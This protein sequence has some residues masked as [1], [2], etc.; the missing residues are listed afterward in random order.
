MPTISLPPAGWLHEAVEAMQLGVTIT[1]VEGRI[2][3][4][5]PAEAEMHG[6]RVEDLIGQAASLFAPTPPTRRMSTEELRQAS[7]W[8]RET[9]NAR[10]DGSVFPVRLLSDVLRDSSGAPVAIVTISEDLTERRAA[11][12]KLQRAQKLEL[13]GQLTGGI[14]HDFNNVLT[15]VLANLDLL[16]MSEPDDAANISMLI[17]ETRQMARQGAAMARQLLGFSR[18]DALNFIATPLDQLV[19]EYRSVLRR[20]LPESIELQYESAAEVPPAAAD[21]HAVQQILLNLVTNARD[22]CDDGG[23]LSIRVEPSRI[24]GSFRASHGWGEPGDYVLISVQDTGSG[25]DA[26]TVARIFDP[27]FTTKPEGSGTGLGMAM[28]Y[29][30]M[31]QHRGFVDVESTPG[32]GTVVRLWFPVERSVH[33]PLP[34]TR[35]TGDPNLRGSETL[36]VVEDEAPIRRSIERGL[37]EYGY[38]VVAAQ[39]GQEALE[40]YREQAADID[41][42]I[43]DL[44][45]PRM[46]GRALADQLRRMG[47][48]VPILFA[49]GY[50]PEAVDAT[51]GEHFLP[52]PWTL[53][54]LL[55]EVR[56]M[57][58]GSNGS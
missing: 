28:V 24:D 4:T 41:L 43:T 46:G 37:K 26:E 5:N 35:P 25:M 39:D 52:K 12:V 58:D 29:S 1:D 6:Y 50:A 3:Y 30:L 56:L 49:S 14:V 15:V 22:A 31:K 19:R 40:R 27:F 23:R 32:S 7:R 34:A 17:E 13:L 42:V 8:E 38:T 20:V 57:L 53:N 18:H 55:T 10:R 45:M 21:R 36:L 51:V 11:E 54:D 2:L 48:A 44:I 9:E 16:A 33:P 47:S